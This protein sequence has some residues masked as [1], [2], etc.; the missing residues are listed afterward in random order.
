MADTLTV[1]G[2]V[3]NAPINNTKAF[4]LLRKADIEFQ[5]ASG[6]VDV[7]VPL[8]G[9]TEPRLV[10]VECQDV[11][12]GITFRRVA[13]TGDPIPCSPFALLADSAGFAQSTLYFSSTASA[14][15]TVRIVVGA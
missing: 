5:L 6:A 8:G 3:R 10:Y 14:T 11:L 2:S 4:S 15:V 9:I 12:D 1:S 7:A 13:T